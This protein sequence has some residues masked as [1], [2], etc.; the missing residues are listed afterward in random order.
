MRCEWIYWFDRINGLPGVGGF[1]SPTHILSRPSA[2]PYWLSFNSLHRMSPSSFSYSSVVVHSH[3]IPNNFLYKDFHSYFDIDC[4]HN[5]YCHNFTGCFINWT[6]SNPSF[7][8]N[9]IL[10]SL[11]MERNSLNWSTFYISSCFYLN[12]WV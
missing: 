8:S 10:T 7:S 1:W 2:W 3:P 11:L 9:P 5:C 12:I 4:H 6:H